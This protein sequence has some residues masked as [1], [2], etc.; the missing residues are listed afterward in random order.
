MT[1]VSPVRKLI[2]QMSLDLWL[3]CHRLGV[4][5]KCIVSH[6]SKTSRY[7]FIKGGETVRISDHFH[8]DPECNANVQII[9]TEHDDPKVKQQEIMRVLERLAVGK[10]VVAA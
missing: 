3:G 7:I 5:A 6:S 1:W 4:S 10:T 9:V 2:A 8:N